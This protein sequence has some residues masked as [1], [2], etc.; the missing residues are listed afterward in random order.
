MGEK[1]VNDIIRSTHNCATLVQNHDKTTEVRLQ[2]C[3][4]Q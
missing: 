2:F 1:K 3:D 4:I